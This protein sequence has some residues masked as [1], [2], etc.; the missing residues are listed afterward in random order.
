MPTASALETEF[1]LWL[2]TE[3]DIPERA[4]PSGGSALL[5]DAGGI[6]MVWLD[7]KGSR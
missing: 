1:A 6:D 7:A 4:L 2:R 5:A 3:P